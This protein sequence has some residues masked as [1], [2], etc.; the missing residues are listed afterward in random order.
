MKNDVVKMGMEFLKVE[1]EQMEA[2]WK[3]IAADI[4]RDG[5]NSSELSEEVLLTLKLCFEYG[6]ESGS[7][8]AIRKISALMP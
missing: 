3:K 4:R 2:Q 7:T 1:K 5:N 8:N 6:W